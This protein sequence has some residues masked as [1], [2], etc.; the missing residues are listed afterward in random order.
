[1]P[2]RRRDLVSSAL[3]AFAASAGS[4]AQPA[5]GT[6]SSDIYAQLVKANDEAIPAVISELN[7]ARPRDAIR[8][9]GT[10]LEALAAAFYAPESSF[11]KAERLIPPL[12]QAATILLKAQHPDG[13]I[14][15]GNLNSPPD[16]GFV[17][18]TVCTALAVLRRR[19]DPRLAKTRDDLRRFILAA[20]SAMATGGIHTPN[21]RWVV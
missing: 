9:A 8:R 7:A 13:S 18:E 1:M 19:D 16:T 20:A 17:V 14:D 4:P 5:Q 11:H 12:E 3:T 21:H 2:I 10:D 15:A 6:A